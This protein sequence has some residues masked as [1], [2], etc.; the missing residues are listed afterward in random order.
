MA[1]DPATSDAAGGGEL[2]KSGPETRLAKQ[3]RRFA[4]RLR[5]SV[6]KNGDDRRRTAQGTNDTRHGDRCIEIGNEGR[7]ERSVTAI[8][9]MC[10]K[11]GVG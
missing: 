1:P 7:M 3:T 6:F 4:S 8:H 10:S 9:H 11:S 2:R 5:T